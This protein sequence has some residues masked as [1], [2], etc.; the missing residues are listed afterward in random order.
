MVTLTGRIVKL[1][2]R[3]S[4]VT[5][6]EPYLVNV[7]IVFGFNTEQ[8]FVLDTHLGPESMKIVRKAIDEQGCRGMPVVVFN[9]HAD[10]DHIWGNCAFTHSF[11]IGHD[12]CRARIVA[13]SKESLEEHEQHKRGD[14]RIVSPNLTFSSRLTFAK[15]SLE[16]VYTPGHTEDSSSCL[17]SIGNLL[18]VGDN[19]ESPVPY[20]NTPDFET[21]LH[22]LYWYQEQEWK[23]LL[24]SHDPLMRNNDL[25]DQNIQYL[26]CLK[27]WEF[28]IENATPEVRH[29]HLH[30][31][32]SL[33]SL[34]LDGSAPPGAREHYKEAARYLDSFETA[35]AEKMLARVK[36]V[37]K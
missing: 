13:E 33:S 25:L 6:D 29:I 36:R 3:V 37:A 16:F 34:F 28:D 24:S 2:E 20:V 12:L 18:F 5:F 9:T 17:D 15:E 30:N 14:V 11:I 1:G 10:Y 19:V 27:S 26:E 21:Y 31:L 23:Y 22:S 32:D 4:V 8:V 35:D 7:C